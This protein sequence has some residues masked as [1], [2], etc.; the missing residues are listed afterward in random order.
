MPKT[1][2]ADSDEE[3]ESVKDSRKASEKQSKVK[4][5]KA[6]KKGKTE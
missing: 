3:G 5:E 2:N 1:L 6:K 4:T